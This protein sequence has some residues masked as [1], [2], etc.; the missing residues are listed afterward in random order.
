[1]ALCGYALAGLL[2]AVLIVPG[3]AIA[4]RLGLHPRVAVMAMVNVGI[5]LL[6]VAT[7]A[8]YPRARWVAVGVPLALCAFLVERVME[9]VPQFWTWHAGLF[10][11]R[12]HPI[13][14]VSVLASGAIAVAT[15]FAL[16]PVRRVGVKPL[17]HACRSCGYDMGELE[18]CPEC[19]GASAGGANSG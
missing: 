4:Q 10:A 2:P 14:T 9:I 3:Q 17:P 19:G 11:A 18:K 7:A 12:L 15:C 8:F 6:F 13:A 1:M 16:S 5:P